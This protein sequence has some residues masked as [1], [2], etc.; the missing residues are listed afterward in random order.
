MAHAALTAD[1]IPNRPQQEGRK[2]RMICWLGVGFA[3]T[4]RRLGA[5]E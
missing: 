1:A 3:G 5:A 2:V 4:A